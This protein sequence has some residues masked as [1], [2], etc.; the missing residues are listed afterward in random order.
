MGRRALTSNM[1]GQKHQVKA[2][3]IKKSPAV[4]MFFQSGKCGKSS[5]PS[6]KPN[7]Q[8]MPST[9]MPSTSSAGILSTS[10]GIPSTSSSGPPVTSILPDVDNTIRGLKK[11]LHNDKVTKAEVLWC[12]QSVM[13][14]KSTNAAGK[15]VNL[16]KL[17]FPDSE[18][19]KKMELR[20]SK[21][22]YTLVFGIAPYFKS[23]LLTRINCSSKFVVSFDESLNK[24]SQRQQMDIVIRFW[25]SENEQV[26]TCYLTSTFLT[27]SKAVDLLNSFK[28]A[29]KDSRHEKYSSNFHG[30]T[31]CEL[32]LPEG[33]EVRIIRRRQNKRVDRFR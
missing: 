5:Q 29:I 17:M 10:S 33:V 12:L 16:L 26:S 15:D 11:H 13:T 7:A 21:I 18:I 28:S 27:S 20:K 4:S 19:A 30:R 2:D 25:D 31:E 22:A 24:K 9:S 6:S 1:L 8:E 3:A 23:Q 14:H 32:C